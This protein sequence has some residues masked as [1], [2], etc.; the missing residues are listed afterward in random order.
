MNSRD[1]LLAEDRARLKLE[2][3]LEEIGS[4]IETGARSQSSVRSGE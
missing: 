4:K 3:E 2:L 1:N